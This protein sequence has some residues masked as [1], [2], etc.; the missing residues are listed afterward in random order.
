MQQFEDILRALSQQLEIRLQPDKNDLCV[1]R[2]NNKLHLQ[3]EFN[4][5]KNRLLLASLIIEIPPGKFREE[6]LKKALQHNDR[7]P[8]IGSFAYASK[9]NALMLFHYIY[10]EPNQTI[11]MI[12]DTIAEFVKLAD[13]WGSAI[14]GGR[15]SPNID[16][17]SSH[18]NIFSTK[19]S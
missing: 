17:G 9:K 5:L 4:S 3:M 16:L 14:N 1:L 12:L 19:K 2:I 7:Y 18:I 11:E 6:V 15:S 13:D 8:R 10:L